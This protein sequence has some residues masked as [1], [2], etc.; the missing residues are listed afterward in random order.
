MSQ[1]NGGRGQ[2]SAGGRFGSRGPGRNSRG[3]YGSPG[4][5]AAKGSCAELSDAIYTCG[6]AK[7]SERYMK[8]TERILNHILAKF[9]QGKYV[10]SSL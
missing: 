4:K 8:T 6:D 10:K 7:Q 1:H 3:N 5:P 9:E 2:G